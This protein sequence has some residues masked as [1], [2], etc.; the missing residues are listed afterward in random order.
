MVI[1]TKFEFYT[2]HTDS[3]L[4]FFEFVYFAHPKC[5]SYSAVKIIIIFFLPIIPT[6]IFFY[7]QF[8]TQSG[9]L[10]F[11]FHQ[12]LTKKKQATDNFLLNQVFHLFYFTDNI[13]IKLSGR[14]LPIR[15]FPVLR[16]YILAIFDE[17]NLILTFWSHD[18]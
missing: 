2:A 18:R 11:T 3:L 16:R 10:N 8:D 7:L 17:H 14:K 5:N 4:T 9:P 1:H 12:Y 6:V 13:P 15:L